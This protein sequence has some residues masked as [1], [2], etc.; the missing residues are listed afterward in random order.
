M[1]AWRMITSMLKHVKEYI[2]YTQQGGN[3][4]Y[5]QVRKKQ[6][7]KLINKYIGGSSFIV[8]QIALRRQDSYNK[9]T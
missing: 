8:P 6:M 3:M 9:W 1:T 2:P 7:M 4:K 5:V